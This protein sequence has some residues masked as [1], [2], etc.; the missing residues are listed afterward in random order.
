MYIY[1]YTCMYI[2][3]WPS[4]ES[5]LETAHQHASTLHD[6]DPA[7]RS[8]T[9]S[10]EKCCYTQIPFKVLRAIVSESQSLPGPPNPSFPPTLIPEICTVHSTSHCAKAL[11]SGFAD[12][13]AQLVLEP[14]RDR[15]ARME[16]YSTISGLY[17]Q[18]LRNSA[19]PSNKP[20]V[21]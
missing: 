18:G 8:A 14:R 3:S 20:S 4:F 17:F 19:N 7:L 15:R 2:H 10:P 13:G 12:D 11:S 9:S 1:I 6:I 21:W 5:A 16:T